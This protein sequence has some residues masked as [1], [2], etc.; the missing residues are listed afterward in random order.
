M[1]EPV[2]CAHSVMTPQNAAYETERLLFEAFHHLRP[3]YM[4]FPADLADATAG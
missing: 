3:A 4:A 2:V 1:S